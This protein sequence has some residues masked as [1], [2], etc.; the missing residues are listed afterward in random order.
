MK[1]DEEEGGEVLTRLSEIASK[2]GRR[3]STISGETMVEEEVEVEKKSLWD[4]PE[5]PV[6]AHPPPAH[7][8]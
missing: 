8:V 1:H 2:R 5:I 6:V 4:I 7:L 3:P